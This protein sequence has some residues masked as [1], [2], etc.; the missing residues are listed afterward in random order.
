MP[1]AVPWNPLSAD[2]WAHLPRHMYG[3]HVE[4]IVGDRVVELLGRDA[5]RKPHY[6]AIAK[7]WR[8]G[9]VLKVIGLGHTTCE[10]MADAEDAARVFVAAMLDVDPFSFYVLVREGFW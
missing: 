3:R 10:G 7:P 1:D 2:T 4:T 5:S 6:T 9:Y 8:Y